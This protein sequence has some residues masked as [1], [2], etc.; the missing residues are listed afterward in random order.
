[1]AL[2]NAATFK[3]EDSG[4][5]VYSEIYNHKSDIRLLKGMGRRLISVLINCVLIKHLFTLIIKLGSVWRHLQAFLTG[6]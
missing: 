5:V 3:V 4:V 2:D 1:M 6:E